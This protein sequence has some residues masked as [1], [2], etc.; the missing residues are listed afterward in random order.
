MTTSATSG[1]YRGGY[2]LLNIQ[3]TAMA[4]AGLGL[5]LAATG[6]AMMAS[7]NTGAGIA[8][9]GAGVVVSASGLTCVVLQRRWFVEIDDRSRA[10]TISTPRSTSTFPADAVIFRIPQ[11]ASIFPSSVQY[12][13]P[14]SQHPRTLVALS[15][16]QRTTP[17]QL[18]S[19]AE[20]LQRNGIFFEWK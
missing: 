15:Q 10:I 6:V 16:G 7:G 19:F 2:W 1:R 18:T 3:F 14:G 8:M 17:S 4:F 12:M 9:L 20:C 5:A 13:Q 11:Q